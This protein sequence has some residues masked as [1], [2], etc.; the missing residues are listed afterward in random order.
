MEGLGAMLVEAQR[1][2]GAFATPPCPQGLGIG[3]SHILAL[4]SK[5]NKS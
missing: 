1:I 4:T 2:L 3:G 5:R